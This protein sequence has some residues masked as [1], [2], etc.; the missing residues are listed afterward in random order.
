MSSTN[1]KGS[2]TPG[3][4]LKVG[5]L[6]FIVP[7]I[8]IIFLIKMNLDNGGTDRASM[9]PE[10]VLS[11]IA[12]VAH[13]NTGAPLPETKAAEPLT[14]EQLYS[15]LCMTCHD[16]GLSGAPIKGDESA[17][18]PRIAQGA[19]TLFKHSLE[20]FNAMPAKGGD[21]SLSDDEVKNAVVFMVNA[22]GGSIAFDGAAGADEAASDEAATTDTATSDDAAATE[23]TTSDEAISSNAA[24]TDANASAGDEAASDEAAATDTTT[25][26]EASSSD[27]ATSDANAS[28]AEES[29]P[30][31][32]TDSA[33]KE[34]TPATEEAA[35]ATEAASSE[36]S[37]AETSAPAEQAD[38][39][40]PSIKEV[41]L[42]QQVP[43]QD[44]AVG[45][46][47]PTQAEDPA[48]PLSN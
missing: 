48:N 41:P 40:Q 43:E 35:P 31:A 24:T 23:T 36:A 38:A 22:S 9:A 39:P 17:W 34:A 10:M 42:N 18:A 13:Y 8:V 25:S 28:A 4:M 15:K 3:E 20:G 14:G 5:A 16:S 12:P 1:H 44:S 37:A 11:R 27:A 30:A 47:S 32:T 2:K 19:D 45:T 26:D 33:A 46:V 21:L 7:I 29:A 6:V